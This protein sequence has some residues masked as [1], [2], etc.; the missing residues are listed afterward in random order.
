VSDL[1]TI[2]NQMREEFGHLNGTLVLEQARREDHPLHDDPQWLWDDDRTAA[3]KYR[4]GYARKL[5][6]LAYVE[7]ERKDGSLIQTRAFRAVRSPD[8]T[9]YDYQPIEDILGD[10][11]RRKILLADMKRQIDELVRSFEG[12]QEFWQEIRRLARRKA[13]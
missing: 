13:S 4:L 3:D 11:L 6:Q 12:V 5:I 7:V 8:A 1:R 2:M 9:Q 10:P